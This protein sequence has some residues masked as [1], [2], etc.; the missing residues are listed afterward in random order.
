MACGDPTD[1]TEL[2]LTT[3]LQATTVWSVRGD[4]LELRDDSGALQVGPGRGRAVARRLVT[5][6]AF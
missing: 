1:T 2:Q 5:G 3:A 6:R 4:T